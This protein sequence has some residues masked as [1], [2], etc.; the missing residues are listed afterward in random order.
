MAVRALVEDLALFA[1][2]LVAQIM[3]G[4]VGSLSEALPTLFTNKWLLSGMHS[5]VIHQVPCFGEGLISV[6]VFAHEDAGVFILR[7]IW[8][9]EYLILVSLQSGVI[10][11]VPLF[12]GNLF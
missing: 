6:I 5:K 11:H 4:E 1:I 2:S 8:I 3:S 7:L 10:D 9:R 12:T